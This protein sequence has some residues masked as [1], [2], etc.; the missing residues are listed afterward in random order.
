MINAVRISVRL[1]AVDLAGYNGSRSNFILKKLKKA[2]AF[3]CQIVCQVAK[4]SSGG[5]RLTMGDASVQR[6][7]FTFFIIKAELEKVR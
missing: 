6:N 1:E 4:H 3:F 2:K 5:N 7:R